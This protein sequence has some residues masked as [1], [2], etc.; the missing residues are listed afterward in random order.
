M[1]SLSAHVRLRPTRIGFLVDPTDLTAV[2]QIMNVCS[3]LWGGVYNPII[4]VCK[5]IPLEW[6]N[7]PLRNPSIESLAKGYI[8]FFEPDVFIEA[9]TGLSENLD[10]TPVDLELGH[11]RILPLSTMFDEGSNQRI[12]LPV[13]LSVFDLYKSLYNQEYKFV[14]RHDHRISQFKAT[15]PHE[16]AFLDAACG[17]FPKFGMLAQLADSYNESFGPRVIKATAKN[18]T[19]ALQ[20]GCRFPLSIGRH[21]IEREPGGGLGEPILFV[22]DPSSPLDLIDLWNLRL[23]R[24][25]VIAI[26]ARWFVASSKF[27]ED[28]IRRNH[29][30]LPGN[31]HGV[32][33]HTTMEFG[34]SISED[35]AKALICEAAFGALPQGSWSLKLW[36]D[37]IWGESQ[38]DFVWRPRRARIAAKMEDIELTLV[39]SDRERSVRFRGLSP[40]FSSKYND[41]ASAWVNVLQFRSYGSHSELALSLPTDYDPDRTQHLRVG[42][43]VLPSTEGLVL[44]QQY[45]DHGEYLR[46]LTGREAMIDWLKQH[47][48]SAR[49]SSAGRVTEQVLGALNG[50]R[51]VRL[52]AHK[53]TLHLL[54]KMAKSVRKYA[55]GSVE[56]YQD[57]TAA[58][59]AWSSLMAKRLNDPW[60][61]NPSIDRF[62]DRNILK[63][64]LAIKCAHCASTNWYAIAELSENV[65]CERCRKTYRFPQGTIIHNTS[66]WKFRVVGPF[67][68]PDYAGGA[69]ATV[70]TLRVF[71][72]TISGMH[73]SI[74]YAPGLDLTP[75]EGPPI[76]VDFALWYSRGNFSDGE[77][78]TVTVFGET[79]SF[80]DKTFHA[81]DVSRMRRIAEKFPGAFL[82]FAAMKD[83]L[84][85][86]ERAAIADLAAWGREPLYGGRPR[87]PVI[88]LT[89]TELFS[90]W[91]IDD[92]WKHTDGLRKQFGETS[93]LR[94]DNLWTLADVTQQIYLGLP[95]RS[96]E[97]RQKWDADRLAHSGTENIVRSD[98][99][100]KAMSKS[101]RL[102]ASRRNSL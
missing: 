75:D 6:D 72:D 66:P 15:D 82:V 21:G 93:Q 18:W 59:D 58:A 64:G 99:K 79:K 63:L 23:F 43:V 85:D 83:A 91:R 52:L 45:K 92:A 47:G 49:I 24:P 55:D 41:S 44:L 51:D 50:L 68:V 86:D 48:L 88:V 62:V 19:K 56:E 10:I 76:E 89:G 17:N 57:R 3:C 11:K 97:L 20:E 87:S 102:V 25:N 80:G 46:L 101:K 35:R 53:D 71:A 31:P 40:D 5:E 22:V 16:I 96:E 32:M 8:K 70:L 27:L 29:R 60:S 36:Y 26:N 9:T 37:R 74:V 95:S 2:R 7:A 61:G 54:D 42:G 13:G 39:E 65:V 30:P 77:G 84:H 94:L 78:E 100:K 98:H 38:D 33:I 4:P 14:A 90:S 81:K 28:F 73:P 1:T 69:Y 12:D 34:R 67:S